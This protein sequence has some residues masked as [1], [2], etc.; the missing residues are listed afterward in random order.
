MATV[1][2]NGGGNEGGGF[3]LTQKAE[4]ITEIKKEI[5]EL[6][7]ERKFGPQNKNSLNTIHRQLHNKQEELK[8][9]RLQGGKK[10]RNH[11]VQRNRT[12]R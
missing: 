12:R 3:F 7:A 4:K 2:A 8:M 5:N 1:K 6:D 10:T 11:R 9:Y